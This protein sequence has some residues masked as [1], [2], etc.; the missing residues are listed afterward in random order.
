MDGQLFR[1]VCLTLLMGTV[2]SRAA[3][4]TS[5]QKTAADF[6]TTIPKEGLERNS[7]QVFSLGP[8]STLQVIDETGKAK[9]LP[10]PSQSDDEASSGPYTA[11]YL[12]ENG[13][14]D[15]TQTV[16]FKDAFPGYTKPLWV[17]EESD[18]VETEKV[19]VGGPVRYTFT[20]PPAEYL[21]GGLSFCV[22]FKTALS[23]GSD[24]ETSTSTTPT[25]GTSAVTPQ[26]GT[27]TTENQNSSGSDT[28]TPP[29]NPPTL[30]DP[31]VTEGQQD[32]P[33]AE[34]RLE[35]GELDKEQNKVPGVPSKDP[36]A[37]STVDSSPGAGV[38]EAKPSMK[39]SLATDSNNASSSK[40]HK[41]GHG[42]KTGVTGGHDGAQLRRL[43]E[44]STEKDA[45][46]TIV[47]HSG[48]WSVSGGMSVLAVFL[49]AVPTLFSI[50]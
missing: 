23:S 25:A 17:H 32:D 38:Q 30:G 31:G 44:T 18:S 15:F 6:T 37:E 49:L 28:S 41:D 34:D 21:G 22:R 9:Y 42:L 48:T 27:P 3:S 1:A 16:D 36:N 7:E 5:E 2:L 10:E 13:A 39:D 47:V 4:E 29:L 11:A 35:N 33:H 14:C 8:S 40:V 26:A 20:N 50:S 45:F 46:L 43:S 19:S 12:F 24:S